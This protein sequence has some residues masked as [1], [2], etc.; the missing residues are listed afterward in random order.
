MKVLDFKL[1][2]RCNNDCLLCCQDRRLRGQNTDLSLEALRAIL[3]HEPSENIEKAILT[4][5]EPTLNRDLEL[6]AAS[7]KE[8]GIKNIQLQTN[9]R[10]LKDR[11]YLENLMF[12]GVTCFGI[13]LHGH[14]RD[15]HEA[16]TQSHG[17]FDDC[18]QALINLRECGCPVSLNCVVTMENLKHL[19]DIAEYVYTER[20]ASSLQFAFIHIIGNAG[21]H[22]DK[23]VRISEAASY[24]KRIIDGNTDKGLKIYTEAIPFCLMGGCEKAVSELYYDNTEVIIF[25]VDGNEL[26]FSAA[27]K[28]KLKHKP[29]SCK[30]CLFNA[31]CE[32]T[33]SEYPIIFGYEEFVPVKSMV[34]RTT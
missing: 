16:F 4:G 6:I 34:G 3:R 32:G 11:R 19:G 26:F 27:R 2:Y 20:F 7:I 31:I 33:W 15:L 10:K 1:T 9:A 28:T 25:D 23:V 22:T 18:I 14:T 21:A 5:G 12:S 17:S 29:E 24:V 30:K 8:K 13:S